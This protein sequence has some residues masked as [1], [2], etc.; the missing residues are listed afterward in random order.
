MAE[1]LMPPPWG[2][3]SRRDPGYVLERLSGPER[4]ECMYVLTDEARYVVRL[5]AQLT[6][7]LW[8]VTI[9]SDAPLED[10]EG[11]DRFHRRH[12]KARITPP[13]RQVQCTVPAQDH[14]TVGSEVAIMLPS[15][16][17]V[18]FLVE[19]Q[20]NYR[21]GGSTMDLTLLEGAWCVDHYGLPRLREGY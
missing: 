15:G 1:I 7:F 3:R 2:Y 13:F 18:G 5:P 19:Y 10:S 14:L 16:Y 17:F 9:L 6:Y 11:L 4:L 21:A 12:P 20:Q 8:T